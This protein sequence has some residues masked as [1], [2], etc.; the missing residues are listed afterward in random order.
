MDQLRRA[1]VDLDRP[2]PIEAVT[3]RFDRLVDQLEQELDALGLP[4]ASV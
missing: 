4:T 2:D 3:T 1:G